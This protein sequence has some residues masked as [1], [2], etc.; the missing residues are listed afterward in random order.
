MRGTKSEI[1]D[2]M[3]TKFTIL[4]KN[5]CEVCEWVI[6][7]TYLKTIYIKKLIYIS[8]IKKLN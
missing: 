3:E 6:F 8:F 4:P 2:K 1:E 7:K 5:N